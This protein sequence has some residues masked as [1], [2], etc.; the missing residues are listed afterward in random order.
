[1]HRD[2]VRGRV[3]EII[4][5]RLF[6]T[7][8]DQLNLTYDVSFEIM[9][10]DRL[11]TCFWMVTVT[12]APPKIA[13]ATQASLQVRSHTRPLLA[14]ATLLSRTTRIPPLPVH[15]LA[16]L[17]LCLL[18]SLSMAACSLHVAAAAASLWQHL[19]PHDHQP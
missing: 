8:R 1:M 15:A 16:P 2:R 10:H 5:S 13:A 12:A 7:V 17:S 18:Q 4:N 9:Q 3:Q 14:G 11:N 19:C 6:V